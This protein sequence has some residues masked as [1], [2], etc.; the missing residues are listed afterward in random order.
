M[1]S[2][3]DT[4]VIYP[5]RRC[6]SR[7]AASLP[8]VLSGEFPAL[9][10]TISRLRLLRRLRAALRC[11]RWALPDR[12]SSSLPTAGPGAVGPGLLVTRRPH[13]D[14][15][16]ERRSPPRFL[17]DPCGHALLFD[18]GGVAVPGATVPSLWP[19]ASCTASAPRTRF[20]G[21]I[22]RP[23]RPL[24]T[25]RSRGRP[26][27]TQHSVPV[28]RQSLPVRDFHPSGHNKRFPVVRFPS[29]RPSPSSRLGLAQTRSDLSQMVQ[30]GRV[31]G[32]MQQR[33]G[34]SDPKAPLVK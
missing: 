7:S 34:A 10:G 4:R 20:R 6:L 13:R 26:R 30:G 28:D 8:R 24:C 16:Q 25:L 23:A 18:P 21:S 17:G 3:S 32:V 29:S 15:G 22:T 9:G 1:V 27:T 12:G 11:L 19:S 14:D 5:S 33:L 2:R 31:S